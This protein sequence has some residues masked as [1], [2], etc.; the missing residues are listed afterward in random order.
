MEPFGREFPRLC[1]LQN[2][3]VEERE[4]AEDV[5]GPSEVRFIVVYVVAT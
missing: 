4:N 1:E 2:S 3:W 5:S